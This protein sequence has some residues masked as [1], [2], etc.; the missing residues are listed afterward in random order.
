M[1]RADR[2]F[3]LL[4]RL[5][6]PI[7]NASLVLFRVAF[8]VMMIVEIA[9]EYFTGNLQHVWAGPAFH[10]SYFGFE[11]LP[12]WSP[13][14]MYVHFAF[15]AI[16]AGFIAIGLWYRFAAFFFFLSYS[17]IFLIEQAAYQNHLYFFCLIGFL[18]VFLPLDR[19]ASLDVHYGRCARSAEIATWTLWIVRFQIGLVY[20]FGG[21]AKLNFDWIHGEPLRIWMARRSDFAIIGPYVDEEWLVYFFVY[22]GL[23]FDLFVVPALLWRKSRPFAFAAVVF[24]NLTNAFLFKI[25][26]FPWVMLLATLIFFE[27]DWP[28]RAAWKIDQFAGWIRGRVKMTYKGVI[29]AS[30]PHGHLA[31]HPGNISGRK[32]TRIVV[33]ISLFVVVHLLLPTRAYLY[34]GDPGWT[35]EGHFFSWRM[36]LRDKVVTDAIILIHDPET[37]E[38][39]P[40][41]LDQ[42]MEPW[43]S[44]IMLRNPELVRQFAWRVAEDAR[45]KGMDNPRVHARILVSM[46]GRRSSLLIDPAVNLA[47]EKRTI[48]AAKW[49]LPWKEN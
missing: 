13:I 1:S 2:E 28:R 49:I 4:E 43:Q 7:D 17:Y 34:P 33:G 38:N 41:S 32:R 20:F 46:N 10:F 8:G 31:S 42:Y 26:P 45:E 19:A 24:F 27:P 22:G 35:D 40:V 47:G 25:G 3:H 23:L 37:G 18:F 14:L 12:A 21:I 16:C 29:D 48:A 15:T 30:T 6:R 11:W 39:I 36:M 5:F 44:R 9:Y